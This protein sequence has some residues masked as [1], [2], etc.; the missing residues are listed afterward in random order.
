MVFPQVI[1]A[2]HGLFDAIGLPGNLLVI[3]T[4]L[5]EGRFHVMRYI[6]LASL[7]LSDFLLL[8]LV[9]SFRIASIAHERWLYGQT[10]CHLNPF[11]LRYFYLNTVLHLLAV[12]YERY[13]AIVKSPLTYDGSVTQSRIMVII[14]IWV[15]PIPLSIA[16]FFGF[17]GTYD[18]NSEVFFCEQGWTV[19]RGRSGWIVMFGIIGSFALPF[20]V[21]VFLNWSVYKTAQSQI[22][23]LEAQAGSI[24]GPEDQQQEMSR[25]RRE[26]KAAVDVSITIAAFLLC[27]LPGWVVGI[28]RQFFRG[29]DVPAEVVLVT[30]CIF[31]LSSLCNPIIYSIRKREFRAGVKKVLRRIRLCGSSS[32]VD[33][34]GI[35]VS[36]SRFVAILGTEASNLKPDAAMMSTEHPNGK[37]PPIPEIQGIDE[38]SP[39][40]IVNN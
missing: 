1:A 2:F 20:L 13:S 18:Y 36:N 3:I 14:L 17:A 29:I 31:F 35:A 40:G 4:I 12:S 32:V 8:I 28:F 5:L 38:A 16:P 30:T 7:A 22:N 34:N 39:N 19:Q 6:L 25:R 24:A 26:W 37:L 27:F 21:I 23:A 11:F 9:N 15:L 10:M 33:S